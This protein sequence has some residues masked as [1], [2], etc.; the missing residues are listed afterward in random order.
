MLYNKSSISEWQTVFQSEIWE[1]S[2][3]RCD[4][5]PALALSYIDLPSHLKVCFAY[6]ALFPKD[7]EFKKEDLIQ[8]WMIENFAHCRQHSR[9]PEVVCQQYFNDLLS[10][11][12]FQQP[13]ENKEVFV[14]HDLLHDLAKYV[15]RWELGQIEKVQKVTRHFSFE[16]EYS[17]YFDGFGT[18]CNIERLRTFVSNPNSQ[19]DYQFSWVMKMSIHEL[20]S[21][22]KFIRILSVSRY[23]N[24]R[25]LPDSIGNLEYLRSLDLSHTPIERLNENLC[26]LSHLQILKLN[27]CTRLEK[28]PSN[29]HLLTNLCRLELMLTKVR[30]MPPYLGKLKNLKVVISS[31][32]VEDGIQQLGELNLEG[33][34]SICNLENIWNSLDALEA[35]LKNKT[36]LVAL[37]LEWE[38][39]RNFIDSKKEE[40]VIENLQPSKNLKELSI[41]RYGGKRF[42]NWLLDNSLW[43]MVS[44]K[45]VECESCQLLPPLGLLPFLKV[46]KIKKLDGILSIDSDFHGN[47]SCSF[48]SLETLE[49][50]NMSRWE[51]WGCQGVTDAFPRLRHLYL[52]NCPKLKEQLPE[53]VIPLERLEIE[54]CKQLE[55]S[56]PRAL[57]LQLR[58]C[59][60]LK[61]E[62]GTMKRLKM[63][64]SLLE[65]VGS[66]DTL[67]NLQIHSP[68]ESINDDCVSLCTFP[69]DLFPTL[70]TLDLSGFGNL[71]MI[72]QSLIHNHLEE[73]TLKNC[74]KLESLLGSMHMLLPS[75]RRLWIQDCPRLES[76]CEGGFPSNLQTL[77]IQDC[78]ILESFPDRG[79]PSNLQTLEIK[80]CPKLKAFPRGFP[81]NLKHL[82]IS[83]CS[84]LVGSLK[85]AFTDTCS[86]KT[87]WIKK[88]DAKCFPD[89][90]LLPLSL[91][92]LTISDCPNL[93][94]LD[95]IGLNLLSCLQNLNLE[96]CPHLQR[97]PEEGLPRSISKLRIYGGCPL[98][99]PRCQEGGKDWERIAHI[100]NRSI[101]H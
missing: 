58:D 35:D 85:G 29:F 100:Q 89:E 50:S 46:L 71:E 73:L 3:E 23:S 45:L 80:D 76:F 68:L 59:G 74:P 8:L 10:R 92:S 60:K 52:R 44:L 78:S 40:E 72:S 63:K 7:Y 4:I 36:Y 24:F 84:R 98:L 82:T 55:A 37:T 11:S 39:N 41:I 20:F 70:R 69:L 65:I 79:F 77:T 87:L 14:M 22:F 95:Y 28:L 33:S 75:L 43:N 53:Q 34:L 38:W 32:N 56:A 6:C 83:N 86:L 48:K 21:K 18:L 94:K 93:E 101:W 5:I 97:L 12:F 15:F 19:H 42:P 90:G 66:S 64:T 27:Y 16:I 81:S 99:E 49:F 57:D 88:L 13:D 1:F 25:E 47:N 9:T 96:N 54:D 26:L 31:F 91:T 62:W 51:K 67:E 61:L 17:Q 30:K 2:K